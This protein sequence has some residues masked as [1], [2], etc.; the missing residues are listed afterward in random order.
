MK[1]SLNIAAIFLGLLALSSCA[2]APVAPKVP[3]VRTET[4]TH[5]VAFGDAQ[6][7]L[8]PSERASLDIFLEPISAPAVS[9]VGLMADDMNPRAVARAR[10]IRNYLVHE[11]V[12]PNLIHLQ[13]AAGMDARTVVVSLEYAR[14]VPPAPCPD[15]SKD[16]S[17]DY[18]DQNM[19]NFG[20]AYYNNLS[21]QIADPNDYIAGHGKPVYDGTRESAIL[22]KYMAGTASS[23]GSA[24]S[25][26]SSGSSGS[27]GGGSTTTTTSSP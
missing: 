20:C 25:S 5:A 23:S 3:H 8:Y 7:A 16:S 1:T 6:T 11:G 18:T 19:S 13:P 14:M 21:V 9:Y 17:M 27:S 4:A 26:S 24:S 10:S 22:Q 12:A 15:W 2:P